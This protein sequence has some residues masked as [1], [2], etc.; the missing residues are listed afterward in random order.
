MKQGTLVYRLLRRFLRFVVRIFYR[1]IEVVGLDNVPDDGPLVLAGNHP[2]SLHDPLLIIACTDRVVHFAAKDTLFSSRFMR[3]F[4]R[5]LGAVPVARKSDHGDGAD[6]SKAFDTLFSILGEGRA[7]GICPEGLSHD[8]SQLARLKTGAARIALGLAEA[9]PDLLVRMV[10]VGLVYVHPK[11]F[12]SRVLVQ[13]GAPIEVDEA[14]KAAHRT[15]AKAAVI[16]L[17]EKLQTA[18][19]GLTVNAEDWETIRVLDAV[20]RLYQ[21]QKITLEQRVELMRR[22][23][24]V[25]PTVKDE[26]SVKEIYA[27][28]SV[29]LDELH[30]AGLDERDL[31]RG[32]GGFSYLV[33]LVQHLSL[34]FIWLPLSL[35]GAL[36]FLPLLVSIRLLTPM[37]TPRRDV[38]ATTKL[39]LGMVLHF[40]S[41]V[42][43]AAV[44]F[45]FGGALWAVLAVI[46]LTIS[47]FATLRVLERGRAILRVFGT[48]F[49]LLTLRKEL[50]VLSQERHT[51]KV[52]VGEAVDRFRPKDMVPLFPSEPSL[53]DASD[54]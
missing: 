4:L 3:F 42:A 1:Q 50:R 40:G 45:W 38:I 29:W 12:R 54:A 49:R 26:P 19:R 20:R 7:M 39:V 6:N 52:I 44:A 24:A 8:E 33:R 13:F 2:N 14:T 31:H 11:K 25:Y 22:F 28:V 43:I 30:A 23:N 36:V 15:D 41:V 34:M 17:T 9:R 47:F 10:P 37:V 48:L 27:R 32:I 35:P 46:G 18:M 53:F 16:G 5:N 21:P 51:L